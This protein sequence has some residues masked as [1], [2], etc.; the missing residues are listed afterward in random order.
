MTDEIKVNVEKRNIEFYRCPVC[1][2]TFTEFKE[3]TRHLVEHTRLSQETEDFETYTCPCGCKFNS[4]KDA[5]YHIELNSKLCGYYYS[6]R[7]D[8]DETLLHISH[9]FS[10]SWEGYDLIVRPYNVC[11]RGG[12]TFRFSDYLE[13]AN[14]NAK[15]DRRIETRFNKIS[16]EKFKK[17]FSEMLEK[18]LDQI[19]DFKSEKGASL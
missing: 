10:D 1:E 8:R 2:K 18:A 14:S 15:I 4:K 13:R 16:E 7:E 17:L 5:E 9:V 19:I 12:T 6:K 11:M 3:M